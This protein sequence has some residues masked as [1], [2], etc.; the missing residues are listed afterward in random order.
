M[1]YKFKKLGWMLVI[2]TMACAALHTQALPLSH[3]T[4]HSKLASG[5]WVKVAVTRSG[6]YQ[7]T[8]EQLRQMGFTNPNN[9]QIYGYGG[10]V[11]S[12]VLNTDLPD[13]L[14]QVP[15]LRRPDKVCFYASGT[16][17]MTLKVN[18]T[19][20]YERLLNTYSQ[21]AYYF[22][23]EATG[24]HS[25]PATRPYLSPAQPQTVGTSINYLH[26]EQEKVSVAFSGSE[27]L[28]ED[29]MN[30]NNRLDFT[31]VNPSDKQ[32][33]LTSRIAAKVVRKLEN[34]KAS[35]SGTFTC[36][37]TT[38]GQTVQIPFR[39]AGNTIAGCL[40]EYTYYQTNYQ[41]AQNTTWV[42][43][44][45]TCHAGSL[46]YGMQLLPDDNQALLQL[47]KIDYFTIVYNQYNRISG[48]DGAQCTMGFTTTNDRQIVQVDGTELTVWD[49]TQPITP[50]QMK[51][52][53]TATHTLFT[54]GT[55]NTPSQYVA[56]NPSATLHEID[57]FQVINNQNLHGLA[58]PNMLIITHHEFMAQ[59]ERV[60]QLHRQHDGMEVLVLDQEQV[61]N[62]F[63]SGTP[64]AMAIR[65]LCKM[66]YDRDK[67]K[68]KYLLIFGN[69]SFDNRGL[70]T[71]KQ[72]RVI[73]YVSSSSHNEDASYINDDFYGYLLDDSGQ[74]LST[75]RLC[76]GIGHM[77]VA[78]ATEAAL[79][80]DKL[81][82]YVYST[83]YGAW[84][85]NYSLWSENS[86]LKEEG[87]MYNWGTRTYTD[88]QGRDS[89]VREVVDSVYQLHESQAAGIGYIIDNDSKTQM[90]RDMAFVRMFPQDPTESFKD[91]KKRRSLEAKRHIKEMFSQG[92]YF[93]TYVGHA[94]ANSMSA[95]GMWTSTDV[96]DTPYPRLP[97]M[98]TACCDVARFDSDH[99]GIA[100]LMFHKRDGGAIAL[101]T[102]TRQV[103]AT[104]NDD[105]NRTFTTTMFSY[106]STGKMPRLGDCYM[107]A[108]NYYN[109][110][111]TNKFHWVLLGDPALG[112]NYPKPLFKIKAINGIALTSGR[113]IGAAPLQRVTIDAEVMQENH[114]SQVNTAF[115]GQ[116]TVTIYDTERTSM[117]FIKGTG[118]HSRDTM[119]LAYPREKLVQVT[120]NVV[121]GKFHGSVVLPRYERSGSG[122]ML[123]SVYAHE[124]GTENMVNGLYDKL[125]KNSYTE[126]T[127][128]SDNIAPIIEAMYLNNE[129]EF[130]AN[131]TVGTHATLYIRAT[132]NTSF[133][134]QQMGL[135]NNIRLTLDGGKTSY[136]L[137]K[138]MA[139]ISDGGS[140]LSIAMPI[141]ALT[142]GRHTMEFAVADV[143]GNMATQTITFV[144]SSQ[145]DI[146][147]QA[148]AIA[149]ST[150]VDISLA[151]AT[152]P[153]LVHIR[154][155]DI[156]GNLVWSKTTDQ[157]P[158][159]W[160]LTNMQ[161]RRVANGLYR[162]YA[163]YD[164]QQGQGGSN[165]LHYVV[166]PTTG[167]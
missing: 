129:N 32:L 30:P 112:I 148:S 73:S 96:L 5:R 138:D 92:Q 151:D 18:T 29:L 24:S 10:T 42:E 39:A 19:P 7:I 149:G 134:M 144:V 142:P 43:L 105:L 120:G 119:S 137:A 155:T 154:V 159:R 14:Q 60:A 74:K 13:D 152:T 78:T 145:D 106:N 147:L 94:G 23:T 71:G 8:V 4:N 133:N 91:A 67:S 11:M 85:N 140:R 166:L 20:Y 69:L 70:V 136:N 1:N 12:E 25:T 56:F 37:L 153:Q 87:K 139:V 65:L 113:T 109:N 49:I 3:F 103:L 95:T 48:N 97:I 66:F 72:N 47:N 84:R 86:T 90:M 83:D 156:N 9:I 41:P 35:V 125:R 2:A 146:E 115:N 104:M 111:N 123:V 164:S 55:V 79:A 6:V 118:E 131:A 98:T 81:E 54:P 99:R 157:L 57:G 110:A 62:E 121:A 108:K 126:A 122:N 130:A 161:G 31:L 135:G 165:L 27:L 102:T 89:V 76:L 16:L 162:I 88:Q 127:A 128:V 100:E 80:V 158:C 143:C 33:G 15:V 58:V 34:S 124:T 107:A 150:A 163:S 167:N 53:S 51:T 93:A 64:N 116:A 28:G 59:A 46:H 160:N 38:G 17:Q 114:P 77:P 101:F 63:S 21:K 50:M 141:T 68:F 75:D 45:D 22:V 82:E 117:P 52:Q 61:F 44:P 26:H 132:D 40:S 36:Q